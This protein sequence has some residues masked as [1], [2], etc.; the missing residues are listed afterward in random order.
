[1]IL[2]AEDDIDDRFLLETAFRENGY[3]EILTFVDD[4]VALLEYLHAAYPEADTEPGEAF[5][6]FIMLDLNMPRKNGQEVL[7]ELK[8][9][10]VYRRI[11][12]II[13]TTTKNEFEVRR[14]YELG[15]STYIVKPSSF[16]TLVE[17]VQSICRYWLNT[18]SLA[19]ARHACPAL[20]SLQD[21]EKKSCFRKSQWK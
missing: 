21:I 12:V 14:C 2:V 8:L 3:R 17:T 11:P 5:P 19:P 1:M 13:Y 4:G 10:P 20:Y 15:A 9:H 7:R 6:G 16:D 18:A